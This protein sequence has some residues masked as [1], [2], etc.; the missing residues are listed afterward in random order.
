MNLLV[1]G[2]DG[3]LIRLTEICVNKITQLGAKL[4]CVNKIARFGAE[5]YCALLCSPAL[6]GPRAQP[7]LCRS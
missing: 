7:F 1:L 5:L 4:Y 6:L 2:P 3:H